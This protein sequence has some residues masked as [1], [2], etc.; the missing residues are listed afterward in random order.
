M[1]TYKIIGLAR[2][3]DFNDDGTCRVRLYGEDGLPS[4]AVLTGVHW[5]RI[6]ESGVR[7]QNEDA[8]LRPSLPSVSSILTPDSSPLTP[9]ELDTAARQNLF[10]NSHQPVTIE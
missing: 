7:S 9:N 2:T 8:G 6:Q 5:E 10:Y 1:T 3:I 4:G